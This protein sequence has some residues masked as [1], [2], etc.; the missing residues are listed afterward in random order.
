MFSNRFLN[1]IAY[2]YQWI[3]SFFSHFQS[4]LLLFIRI[5]WGHQF[6]LMGMKKLS[7]PEQVSLFFESLGIHMPYFHVYLVGWVEVIGGICLFIGFASRLIAIPL[8]IV[9]VVAYS[10]A[11]SYIFTHWTIVLNPHI[12]VQ[13]P[14]FAFLMTCLLILIFGPGKVSVDRWIEKALYKRRY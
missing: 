14:P 1:G 13:E 8:G 5:I 12:I 9:L 3:I 4:L 7:N 6:V 11:H 10:T 2:I